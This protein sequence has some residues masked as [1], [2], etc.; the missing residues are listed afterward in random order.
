MVDIV[1][2]FGN[3]PVV[4]LFVD[5]VA[6]LVTNL[7]SGVIVVIDTSLAVVILSSGPHLVA[8]APSNNTLLALVMGT[9]PGQ[10]VAR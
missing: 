1:I 7:L 10:D 2:L 9:A 3:S 6:D 8:V 4:G 5:V